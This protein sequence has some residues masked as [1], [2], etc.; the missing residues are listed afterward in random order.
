MT[1]LTERLLSWFE[2]HQRELP[3]RETGD[4]YR[5]WVSEV[6][7]QQTRVEAVVPKYVAFMKRFPDVSALAAADEEAVLALWRGLGYYS[8]ARRLHQAAGILTQEYGSRFPDYSSFRAL[9]G[10]GDYTADAVFSIAFN[11]PALAVDGNI[12]RVGARLFC[13]EVDILT[14]RAKTAVR[15]AFRSHL[16]LGQP[17]V[18]NQALMDLGS[19]VCVPRKPRCGQCPVAVCC[20]A[21]ETGRTE[22]LPRRGKPPKRR[23]TP[24]L[25]WVVHHRERGVLL[26]RRSGG[27]FLQGLWE[28]PWWETEAGAVAAERQSLYEAGY[29]RPTGRQAFHEY[30]FSHKQWLMDIQEFVWEGDAEL[31]W[32]VQPEEDYAWVPLLD[33]RQLAVASAFQ[34]VYEFADTSDVVRTEE[35]SSDG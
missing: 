10:V 21:Y 26:R 18:F 32:E 15:T 5:I 24:V 13:L 16:A 25:V 3:W 28:F 19:A 8:R 9:P 33:W 17:G 1:E 11:R 27:G 12:L 35:E 20:Q 30:A 6:M 22:E 14:A 2:Q 31:P 34:S 4:P 7:L 23:L 29:L